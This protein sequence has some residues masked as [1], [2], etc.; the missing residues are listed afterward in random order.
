MYI[1]LYRKW[2]PKKFEEVCGQE[3]ITTILKNQIKANQL[4]HAYLLC[5]TRGTGKTS[6]AKLLAK[7]VNCFN[8]ADG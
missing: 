3:Q 6:T 2:R 4:S 1:A 7:A 5:G 8:L